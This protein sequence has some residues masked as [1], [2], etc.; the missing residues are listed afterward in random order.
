MEVLA[1]QYCVV[2]EKSDEEYPDFSQ[3]N[4]LWYFNNINCI[5]LVW[6]VKVD[7]NETFC[8]EE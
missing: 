5:G 4:C 3:L 6:S 2:F 8:V 1:V 7:G